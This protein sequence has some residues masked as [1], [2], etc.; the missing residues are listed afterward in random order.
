MDILGLVYDKALTF[1]QHIVM[2]SKKAA[3]KIAALRRISWLVEEKDLETLYKAQIRSA[4]EFA[5]LAWGG[6]SPTHLA[7]LDKV[8]RRAERV[9]HGEQPS[10]LQP[11]QQR[12]DVAGLSAM[13]RVQEQKVEHLQELRRPPRPVPRL[14]REATRA[15][16]ALAVPRCHTL[17]H[18]RQFVGRYT[19]LW[20]TFMEAS[21][22]VRGWTLQSF[23]C[24]VNRWLFNPG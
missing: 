11:L 7:L 15:H 22:D 10:R 19:Q 16:R 14:T 21:V 4:M 20:N 5:P 23:K 12:R 1:Q 9:I 13:F 3:G 2:I 8:Q 17:H 24:A 6:A 18:Q